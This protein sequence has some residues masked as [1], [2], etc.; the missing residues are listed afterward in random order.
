MVEIF[1]LCLAD[2]ERYADDIGYKSH[3]EKCADSVN[4]Y[5]AIG[6]YI[7]QQYCKVQL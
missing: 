1:K 3:K 7:G 6:Q 5:S 4:S 2:T